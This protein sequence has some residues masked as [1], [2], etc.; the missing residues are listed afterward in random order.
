MSDCQMCHGQG[1]FMGTLGKLDWYCCRDC[2]MEFNMERQV[3][4]GRETGTLMPNY[5]DNSL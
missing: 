4:P 5:A 3:D 1:V 2:G